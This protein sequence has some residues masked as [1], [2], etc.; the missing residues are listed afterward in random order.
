VPRPEHV[1]SD[2]EIMQALAARVGLGEALAGDARTWKRRVLGASLAQRGVTLE[3]LETEGPIKNPLIGEIAFADR[4]FTTPSGRANLI[5]EPPPRPAIP[6]AEFPLVLMSLSTEKAQAS[7]WARPLDGPLE[8]T[9]HPEAAAGIAHGAVARLESAI[10]ALTV[11]VR[12]DPAQRRDVALVPKGGRF[13]AGL[14]AN[15]LI[16]A[17]LSDH[18]EGAALDELVRLVALP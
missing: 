3:R 12:H 16:R 7:Q 15:T 8:V 11:R 10:A 4:R 18:G 5:T 1:R 17:R 14:C 13:H 2:L 6:T 9:V